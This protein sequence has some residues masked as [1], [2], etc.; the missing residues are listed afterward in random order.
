MSRDCLTMEEEKVYRY[1]KEYILKHGYSPCIREICKGTGYKSKSSISC[2]ISNLVKK[3]WLET[4]AEKGS[5][6]AFRLSGYKI[7]KEEYTSLVGRTELKDK[8]VFWDVDGVL[9]P[10][11]FNGHLADPDGTE[12]GMSLREI[13]DGVFL[14]REPS[15]YMQKVVAEC[16]A[17]QS[18]AM[19][20]CRVEKEKLDK[21]IWIDKFY[22]MIKERLLVYVDESK[23]DTILCY[24]KEQNI[25]VKEVIFVD[26][27]LLYLREAERKGITSY[28]ISSF[29]DWY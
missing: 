9:A 3:K 26:D 16:G 20:H 24:C 15:K 5:S 10:Y 29:L 28:H 14:Y 19:G 6:R 7:I 11:R 22:P 13:Q 21:E 17:K 2:Y 18:I 8:Y 4:D 25:D 27:T 12:N 23:A 1:I